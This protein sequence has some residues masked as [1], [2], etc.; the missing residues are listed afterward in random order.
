MRLLAIVILPGSDRLDDA[1]TVNAA[2]ILPVEL[3]NLPKAIVSPKGTVILIRL[4]VVLDCTILSCANPQVL[5]ENSAN[6]CTR[7]LPKTLP[8]AVTTNVG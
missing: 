4:G 3:S 6:C 7:L 1:F 8:P 2:A 5:L